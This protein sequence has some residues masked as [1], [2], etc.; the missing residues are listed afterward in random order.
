MYLGPG[1]FRDALISKLTN[2]SPFKTT[3]ADTATN[4][5]QFVINLHNQ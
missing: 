3:N 2:I 4:I 1:L 5:I